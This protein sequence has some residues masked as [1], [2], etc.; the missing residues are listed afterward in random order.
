MGSSYLPPPEQNV[1]NVGDEIS[2]SSLDGINAASPGLSAQNPVA[3]NQSIAA[4]I[5][6]IPAPPPAI[7]DYDNFKIYSGGEI[8]LASNDFY[9]FNTFI[10]AAGYGPITHPGAWTKLSTQN[11][12]GY[13]QLSGAT[14]TGKVNAVSP[15]STNAGLNI[16]SINSTANLTSSVAGDVWI[17]TWQIAYKTANGTLIYGAATNASNV[18]GSPQVI[19]T[20]NASAALRVTQKGTGNAIE[21]EDQTSPD[22]NRFVVDQFGKVGIGVAPDATAALKV[23]ANGIMFGD[24][25]RQTTA[26]V[27]G[28]QGIPGIP[29]VDAYSYSGP[30]NSANGYQVGSVVSY[31]GSSWVSTSSGSGNTPYEG[32]Y[33][34]QLLA[35]RGD[36]GSTG[37][38]GDQGPQGSNGSDGGQGPAGPGVINWRGAYDSG[39][40]Y[41]VNDAVE[42][43]GSS[44]ISKYSGGQFG[45]TPY[46]GSSYW[47]LLAQRGQNGTDGSS[48][49]PSYYHSVWAYNQWY[50]ASIT[51]VNDTNYNYVNVL[52]F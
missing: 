3:S 28:P 17:G 22:P 47:G 21:V 12:A 18:F 2:V 24:G 13:A 42:Y 50:S 9:R 4:A 30:Y 37:P 14:F 29:G 38:Q 8:V 49:S 26:I 31:D 7:T 43:D 51:T 40:S 23:D 1:V 19:D 10:G 32:S 41:S 11:L 36:M 52:T 20:T 15:T 48:N 46:S 25:T 16:G 33:Q 5:A 44:Y 6:A 45:N 27:Q 35:R 34:W 39:T